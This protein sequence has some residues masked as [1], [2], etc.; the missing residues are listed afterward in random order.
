MLLAVKNRTTALQIR[1]TN[2][3]VDLEDLAEDFKQEISF[4]EIL[5]LKP[6]S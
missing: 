2:V 4:W 3:V 1:L 6:K 5:L